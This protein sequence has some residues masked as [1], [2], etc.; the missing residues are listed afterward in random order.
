M[1]LRVSME[2]LKVFK[3]YCSS[4]VA[5]G[6]WTVDFCKIRI[7]SFWE[8][9]FQSVDVS[10][11]VRHEIFSLVRSWRELKWCCEN[12]MAGSWE[13]HFGVLDKAISCLLGSGWQNHL[14]N[15]MCLLQLFILRCDVNKYSVRLLHT[16]I[17]V[18]QV[19]VGTEWPLLLPMGSRAL[20][21]KK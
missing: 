17:S 18:F 5:D 20:P 12:G 16:G 15:V 19:S 8:L 3:M 7:E 11:S 9:H 21:W 2:V 6:S 14:W 1:S 13:A 10:F 4:T